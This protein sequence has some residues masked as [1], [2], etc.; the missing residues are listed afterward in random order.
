MFKFN[1]PCTNSINMP[2]S[3]FIFKTSV[4]LG[5]IKSLMSLEKLAHPLH[6]HKK[7]HSSLIV[8]PY[9]TK[10]WVPWAHA[11]P[12]SFPLPSS[13]YGEPANEISRFS[14][15]HSLPLSESL[16]CGLCIPC[17]SGFRTV[18]NPGLKLVLVQI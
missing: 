15:N 1:W 8:S 6:S 10:P 2:L 3:S 18:N 7:F 13:S 16:S 17:K 9:N 14:A 11:V 12:I 5:R 4:T